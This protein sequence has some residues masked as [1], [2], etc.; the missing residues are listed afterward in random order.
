MWL[1]AQPMWNDYI[2]V[3]HCTD[4]RRWTR[5]QWEAGWTGGGDEEQGERV[6]QRY[7]SLGSCLVQGSLLPSPSFTRAD[8]GGGG[9]RRE[10]GGDA[11]SRVTAAA[12]TA[13]TDDVTICPSK[14]FPNHLRVTTLLNCSPA[15]CNVLTGQMCECG[16]GSGLW[17]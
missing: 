14:S 11:H 15:L 16:C 5:R 3:V 10:Q 7:K 17:D 1:C 13:A 4:G 9:G 2:A 6:L 12:I 8:P